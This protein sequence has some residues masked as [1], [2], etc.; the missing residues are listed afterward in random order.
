MPTV[1]I[2]LRRR[3]LPLGPPAFSPLRRLFLFIISILFAGN[4]QI[5]TNVGCAS[6]FL[7]HLAVTCKDGNI[8]LKTSLGFYKL[9]VWRGFSLWFSLT[10][11]IKYLNF[12][13][14][15]L[16]T[17]YGFTLLLLLLSSSSDESQ[18][19]EPKDTLSHHR[20]IIHSFH[21]IREL[22]FSYFPFVPT[23]FPLEADF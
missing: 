20:I 11:D 12:L 16:L 4:L 14:I 5:L 21:K 9:L 15:I 6:P 8:N 19:K 18:S 1:N 7:F 22:I 3:H 13:I 10:L 2:L 17:Y 23:E